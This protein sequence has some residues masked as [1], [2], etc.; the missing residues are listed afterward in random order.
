MK[1]IINFTIAFDPDSRLLKL[2][3][4]DQLTIELSKPATRLL[5]EL[6]KNNKNEMTR[7]TLIEHVWEDYGFSPS[8]AT[9]SN[10]I[11]ELRK[12]FEVL[13]ISKDI[14]IT[15]PRVG[16]KLEAE[17]HPETK[18]KELDASTE[19]F[20]HNDITDDSVS[21]DK[22]IKNPKGSYGK[23][24]LHRV[25][26]PILALIFILLSTIAIITI[27]TS[28][29]NDEPKLLGIMNKCKFYALGDGIPDSELFSHT[30][31]MLSNAEIDCTQEHRDIF[32]MESLSANGLRKSSFM[33]VCT[34]NAKM[35]YKTCQNYKR[36]D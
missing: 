17:I 14:L 25:L 1:Y 3:N 11:S 28:G 27:L 22:M 20:G 21:Q 29:R 26:K 15:V 31:V 6:I 36:I 12:A 23:G 30:R 24:K 2:R 9:L 10:H 35:N 18:N 7:E 19:V 34:K 16:F 5:I 8:S 4:K 13:G 33:V 32:F